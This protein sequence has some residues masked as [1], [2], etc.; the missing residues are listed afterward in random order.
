DYEMFEQQTPHRLLR[1]EYLIDSAGPGR[2]RGGLGVETHFV[3]GGED[4]ELVTFGDGD[5]EAAFGLDGGGDGTLN[6]IELHRPDGQ[7][8]T[9]TSKDLVTGVPSGTLYVQQAGGG[10]GY[11]NPHERAAHKV[12]QEVR[13]ELISVAAARDIY[14]VV[15]DKHTLE[16]DPAATA[17]LRS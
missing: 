14:G 17:K 6:K 3:M 1:H 12:A 11:G 8:I 13:D 15:V 7:V 16:L 9:P 2:Q 10:G 5:E 4:L